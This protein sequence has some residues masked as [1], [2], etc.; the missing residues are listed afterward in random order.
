MGLVFGLGF[1]VFAGVALQDAGSSGGVA[2]FRRFCGRRPSGAE[3]S[4]GAASS[5]FARMRV[6][7]LLYYAHIH[8]LASALD[9]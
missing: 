8:K 4:G 9:R 5:V 2:S 7:L 6:A 3:S 1:V